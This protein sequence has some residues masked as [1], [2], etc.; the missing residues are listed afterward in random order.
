MSN[1][2][3]PNL[4]KGLVDKSSKGKITEDYKQKATEL[5]NFYRKDND[6][7]A[8]RPPI[9][10][11]EGLKNLT[12]LYDFFVK[13]D[14][15][16][17]LRY[18]K[19]EGP[20]LGNLVNSETGTVSDFLG[21]PNLR[22]S[23]N[24][25]HH[26]ARSG[27]TKHIK[28]EVILLEKYDKNFVRN[29]QETI[30]F[31]KNINNATTPF[32]IKNARNEVVLTEDKY[33][34]FLDTH[35]GII[36][37]EG[38][39]LKAA[40]SSLV[41][42]DPIVQQLMDN[43]PSGQ[44]EYYQ[45]YRGNGTADN[46][47]LIKT[48]WVDQPVNDLIFPYN[49]TTTSKQ[50]QNLFYHIKNATTQG[51]QITDIPW[52]LAEDF[53]SNLNFNSDE[54]KPLH[55]NFLG[56]N[57]DIEEKSGISFLDPYNTVNTEHLTVNTEP[58]KIKSED[59][60]VVDATLEEGID[61][62]D[63]FKLLAKASGSTPKDPPP[64]DSFA[65]SV[66]YSLKHL[67]TYSESF[68]KILKHLTPTL[69]EYKNTIN[70]TYL[71][72][73]IKTT[74]P[75][76]DV[77]SAG[78]YLFTLDNGFHVFTTLNTSLQV[79]ETRKLGNKLLAPYL[80]LKN[81]VEPFTN[82]TGSAIGNYG[83]TLV[84]QSNNV[85]E[86]NGTPIFNAI[87]N[88]GAPVNGASLGNTTPDPDY[89]GRTEKVFNLFIQ[90]DVFFKENLVLDVFNSKGTSGMQYN[91]LSVPDINFQRITDTN[92]NLFIK[93]T[94]IYFATYY[95]SLGYNRYY[96][97]VF[98]NSSVSERFLITNSIPCDILTGERSNVDTYIPPKL[99]SN[100]ETNLPNINKSVLNSS[101][102]NSNANIKTFFSQSDRTLAAEKVEL[103]LYEQLLKWAT[104]EGKE[105]LYD[106]YQTGNH[107]MVRLQTLGRPQVWR[108][109]SSNTRQRMRPWLPIFKK[110]YGVY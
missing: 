77:N 70:K 30:I 54:D 38:I 93:D 21:F 16:Y 86:D 31:T 34:F 81:L 49:T 42:T 33:P 63:S 66:Y 5:T 15:I 8:K 78:T 7:I 73:D 69:Y 90:P 46:I 88:K 80:N 56:F 24:L 45:V 84:V 58:I 12:G 29:D 3:I 43:L 52:S 102:S 55:F 4:A 44:T 87:L 91:T 32:S 51:D 60:V 83:V 19:Q 79:L 1:Y 57:G 18:F 25:F 10:V 62:L 94:K 28:F 105:T 85:L 35:Q 68:N 36:P 22:S 97:P 99:L 14:D 64:E 72:P 11:V 20:K 41:H 53:K 26:L 65:P 23:L 2:F 13:G 71:V 110:G 95:N 98:V 104:T 67:I 106:Y 37:P 17:T 107:P 96:Y 89:I 40:D 92:K 61:K 100:P 48:F 109:I 108:L 59:L 27:Y 50:I 6:N 101:V 74:L 82:N 39:V 9:E 75:N 76:S 47:K 103:L